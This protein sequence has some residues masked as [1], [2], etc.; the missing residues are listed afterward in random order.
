M[1]SRSQ[2]IYEIS[3]SQLFVCLSSQKT[4]LVTKDT[5]I[6]ILSLIYFGNIQSCEGLVIRITVGLATLH[7]V[8]RYGHI[9]AALI[10]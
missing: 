7:A 9:T 6:L 8:V 5:V 10:A 4:W 3:R 1:D 2:L